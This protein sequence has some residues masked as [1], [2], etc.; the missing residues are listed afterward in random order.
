M[1]TARSR[2]EQSRATRIAAGA[3][4]GPS[5]DASASVSRGRSLQSGAGSDLAPIVTTTQGGL[6]ASWEI[7]LFGGNRASRDA[8]GERLAGAQAQWHDARVS[9]AAEVANQYYSLRSCHQLA[10]VTRADAASRQETARL[11]SLSTRAGFT[12]RPPMRWHAPAPPKPVAAPRSR[13]PSASWTSRR[14]WP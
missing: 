11:S 13:A 10:G 2:I 14:W 3:A 6:Q 12:A 4:L 5:L 7:D 8:A 9:V 1:A